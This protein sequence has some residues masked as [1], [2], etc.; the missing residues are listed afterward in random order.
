MCVE[1]RSEVRC[2]FL[3]PLGDFLSDH[4]METYIKLHLPTPPLPLLKTALWLSCFV[5]QTC[6]YSLKPENLRQA[7]EEAEASGSPDTAN[8]RESLKGEEG[9]TRE[10]ARAGN[11]RC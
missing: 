9:E 5:R 6:V 7:A 1:G 2:S 3:R 10:A 4:E 8:T 11:N